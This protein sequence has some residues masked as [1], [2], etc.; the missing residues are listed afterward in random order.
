MWEIVWK[1]KRYAWAKSLLEIGK[2]SINITAWILA[3]ALYS[4]STLFV[5]KAKEL[6][7][8]PEYLETDIL[9]A[10]KIQMVYLSGVFLT[11]LIVTGTGILFWC[12]SRSD[13]K[14][15]YPKIV[16]FKSLGY[17]VKDILRY[18]T[19][20]IIIDTCISIVVSV[21]CAVGA[22]KMFLLMSTDYV[23]L[24]AYVG[25]SKTMELSGVTYAAVVA[26][27]IQWAALII[28]LK[29][30]EKKNIIELITEK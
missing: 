17:E 1:E 10:E 19:Y 2:I 26:M 8:T 14:K 25:L 4:K 15:R 23:E 21:V 5:T 13:M 22:W 18:Y 12:M 20:Q 27:I 28:S 16:F 30:I 3:Y 6:M 24:L 9:G 7:K 29:E 11:V